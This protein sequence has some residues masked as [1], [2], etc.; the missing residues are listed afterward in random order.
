VIPKADA[1]FVCQMEQVLDEYAKP[2]EQHHP[3]VCLDESPYQMVSEI[4]QSF[5]DSKGVVHTDYEYRR[6]GVVDLY[7]IVE[8]LDGYREVLVEDNHKGHTYAKVLAHLVEQIYPTAKRITLVE[9]NSSAHKLAA[10][11]EVF[12]PERARNII[13]RLHVVRTPAHGSWLNIAECELSVL[14]RQGIAQRVAT[15]EEL[16]KQVQA[17]YQQRNQKESKVDW[18]FTTKQARIKLKRL[19]PSL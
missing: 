3:V 2:Y 10:L 19:Y 9:D 18:Q 1:A 14:K 8:P 13:E 4:R 6:E 7:M 17:W 5:T 11:Y 15:K 16:Q 12:P